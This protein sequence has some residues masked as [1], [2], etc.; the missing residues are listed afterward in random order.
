[1]RHPVPNPRPAAPQRKLGYFVRMERLVHRHGISVTDITR[2]TGLTEKSTRKML[3][4]GGPSF[5]S[6]VQ[7]VVAYLNTLGLELEASREFV[8][9]ERDG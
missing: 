5:Y 7:E 1:M 8:E 3:N 4:Q 9:E 2:A 6:S